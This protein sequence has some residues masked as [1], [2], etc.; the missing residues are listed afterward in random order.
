MMAITPSLKVSNLDFFI[1]IKKFYG[2]E[3]YFIIKLKAV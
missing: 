3:N 2:N 1:A